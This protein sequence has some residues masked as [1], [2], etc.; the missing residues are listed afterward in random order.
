VCDEIIPGCRYTA[1]VT[2]HGLVYALGS[3]IVI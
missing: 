1:W 2:V 3:S